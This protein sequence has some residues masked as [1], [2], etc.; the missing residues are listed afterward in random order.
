MRARSDFLAL[1]SSSQPGKSSLNPSFRRLAMPPLCTGTRVPWHWHWF[2]FWLGLAGMLQVG[3]AVPY[4]KLLLPPVEALNAF[5]FLCPLLLLSRFASQTCHPSPALN[6]LC[7]VKYPTTTVFP[8]CG[9]S[10]LFILLTWPRAFLGSA[11]L[12]SHPTHTTPNSLPEQTQT[13][14]LPPHCRRGTAAGC[15]LPTTLTPRWLECHLSATLSNPGLFI[16]RPLEY[17]TP[18]LLLFLK[19][20]FGLWKLLCVASSLRKAHPSP[21]RTPNNDKPDLIGIDNHFTRA[22]LRI[23]N[24]TILERF[25]F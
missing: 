20:H 17:Q 22:C 7:S 18:P 5:L 12:N 13:S 4:P 21:Y 16:Y 10:T 2:W 3:L 15:Y 8:T 1:A 14:F 24:T 19:R 11:F 25:G 9:L 6:G 23:A